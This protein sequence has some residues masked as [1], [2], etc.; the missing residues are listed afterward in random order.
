MQRSKNA[1]RGIIQ[2]QKAHF[3]RVR[4]QQ[5][6]E[7]HEQQ[8]TSFPSSVFRNRDQVGIGEEEC[9]PLSLSPTVGHTGQGKTL[10]GG[11]I[12]SGILPARYGSTPETRNRAKRRRLH[13]QQD[14]AVSA[15][16]S[17]ECVP[18]YPHRSASPRRCSLLI[19]FAAIHDQNGREAVEDQATNVLEARKR[20]LLEQGDW[21]G[22]VHPKAPAMNFKASED[23][24]MIGKRRK[25]TNQALAIREGRSGFEPPPLPIQ[26]SARGFVGAP[27][28]RFARD[29]S[30]EPSL[31]DQIR[32]RFVDSSLP[33]DA[34]NPNEQSEVHHRLTFEPA[35][36]SPAA[37]WIDKASRAKAIGET[38]H[39]NVIDYAMA[40]KIG[41]F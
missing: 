18:R 28:V 25:I 6:H 21:A 41:N 33:T 7:Q 1:N 16:T 15:H 2:R 26:T 10:Q 29:E 8:D 34:I 40:T 24:K 39:G 17:S 20:K 9:P 12:G 4:A 3:A 30:L 23:R 5:Q 11:E 27:R 35:S 31:N 38:N 19:S 32:V 13:T 37:A 36:K 14:T 22:L